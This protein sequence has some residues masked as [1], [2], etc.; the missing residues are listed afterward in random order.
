MIGASVCSGIG[1]AEVAAPWIKWKWAC[2]KEDFPW[3]VLH[4]RFPRLRG[5]I[6]EDMTQ[7]PF[8]LPEGPGNEIDI[9]CGGTPCQ[10]FSV[11]GQRSGMDD[12]R[13]NLTMEFPRLARKAGAR[14]IVWENVP[15]VLTSN[16]GRD[17]A[18]FL[19]EV[20]K[21]GYWWAYRTLDAHLVHSRRFTRALPQRR[22]RVYLVGHSRDWRN[23]AR[24]LFEPSGLPRHTSP[25]R[26]KRSAGSVG[27]AAD[28]GEEDRGTAFTLH[29]AD[30]GSSTGFGNL[31]SHCVSGGD[32]SPDIGKDSLV[33]AFTLRQ[34]GGSWGGFKV[35][36]S[37]IIGHGQLARTLNQKGDRQ[38]ASV[39]TFIAEDS[40]L[41][42]LMPLEWERLQGFPD[43][44]TDIDGAS[45]MKR[46]KAI[47]NAW[48]VN[49]AE[50]VLDRIK[51][52]E[53]A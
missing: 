53:G 34:G 26:E 37:N 21:C 22:E 13:G 8:W 32:R 10:T 44:W 19:G 20:E 43:G 18:A 27:Y 48:A 30:S 41:R 23:P 45:E 15:G 40:L 6:Y 42:R 52:L 50:W 3:R 1:G 16:G 36:N 38:D 33:P 24:I 9:L 28:A 49:C 35:E 11:A 7:W 25:S 4:H 47:G 12:P 14:W 31:I 39:D 29:G 51:A 17:F 2:E 5:D 46:Y